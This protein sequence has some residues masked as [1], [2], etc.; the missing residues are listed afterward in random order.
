MTYIERFTCEVVIHSYLW[1]RISLNRWIK[2]ETKDYPPVCTI[3]LAA[4]W[5][6][7]INRLPNAR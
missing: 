6:V 4:L 5:T 1:E 2:G 3:I 7:A